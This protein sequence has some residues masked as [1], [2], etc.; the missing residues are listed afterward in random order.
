MLPS[1]L[2]FKSVETQGAERPVTSGMAYIHFS[3]EGLVE[4]S[5]VQITDGKDLT[6][7]LIFNPITGQ[8][9]VVPKAMTLKD[10]DNL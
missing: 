4:K 10:F 3:P 6:W 8:A 5:I 9:E 7:S 2:R 1:S